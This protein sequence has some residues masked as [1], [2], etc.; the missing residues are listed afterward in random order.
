YLTPADARAAFERGAIDAW[1][2]WD[3]FFAAAE[4][5]LGAR[6]LA[7]GTGVVNNSQYV[8]ASKGYAG[9]RPDVLNI[10]LDELKKTDTWAAANPKDVTNILG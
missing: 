2:I 5:Q 9:A 8:L 4:Q 7:D 1:V 3:P 6:V 10:V